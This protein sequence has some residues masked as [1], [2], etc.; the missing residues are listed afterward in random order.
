[1]PST[2]PAACEGRPSPELVVECPDET[3]VAAFARRLAAVL[4]RRVV[5]ALEGDLG[6]GKTT[7]VKKLAAAI[8]IDPRNVTSPTF[9]L[10][11]EYPVPATARADQPA[12]LVHV[13]AYRLTGLADLETIGWEELLARDGWLAIE[14]PQRVAPALPHDRITIAI[15]VTG[16]ETRRIHLTDAT[17]DLVAQLQS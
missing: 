3:A 10:V 14:W 4:P 17:G 11:H 15:D 1:M 13:D 9:T 7:F 16:P 12:W 8:G 2:E 5:L 6:A